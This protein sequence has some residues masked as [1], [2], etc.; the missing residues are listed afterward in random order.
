MKTEIELLLEI[1][2]AARDLCDSLYEGGY[3]DEMSYSTEAAY[4]LTS[5][6][7]E[8]RKACVE[9]RCSA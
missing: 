9:A 7:E 3:G 8:Y 6:L 4:A 2:N 1:K 5:A